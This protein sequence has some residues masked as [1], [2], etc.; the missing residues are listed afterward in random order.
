MVTAV[1]SLAVGIDLGMTDLDQ[2]AAARM[3]Q[4]TIGNHPGADVMINHHLNDVPRPA[5]RAKQRFRHRPCADIVLNIDRDAGVVR[6]NLAKRQIFDLFIKWHPV[7]HAVF[8]INDA[9]H[10]NGDG[11]QTFQFLLMAD[12]ELVD[13]LNNTRQERLFMAVAV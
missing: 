8:G 13:M 9:R 10:G 7:N 11:G 5:G 6:Q 1:A 3:Q 2:T 4:A 12:K